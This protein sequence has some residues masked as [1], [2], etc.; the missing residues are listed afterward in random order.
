MRSP[1]EEA[2]RSAIA[3]K[4]SPVQ[5]DRVRTHHSSPRYGCA[6]AMYGC[7]KAIAEGSV[8]RSGR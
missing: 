4:G 5:D 6:K 3:D 7:A 2:G 8:H 1:C